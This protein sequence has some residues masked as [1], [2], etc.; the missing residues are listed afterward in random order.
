MCNLIRFKGL[1]LQQDADEGM[2]KELESLGGDGGVIA[3]DPAGHMVWSMNTP[4]MFRDWLAGQPAS[5]NSHPNSDQALPTPVTS[6]LPKVEPI[7]AASWL[8]RLG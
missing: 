5:G 7:L 3:I 4:G 8:C 2:R 6:T 1:K